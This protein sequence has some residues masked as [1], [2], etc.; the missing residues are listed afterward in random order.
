M[1]ISFPDFQVREFAI[2]K[3]ESFLNSPLT[4]TAFIAPGGYGKTTIV[5]QLVEIFFTGPHARYPNDIVCL[6]DGSI[7]LNLINL[8]LEVVRLKNIFEFEQRNSF[9]VYFRKHPEQVRGRFV[10]IIESLYQIYHQE[11]KLNHFVENLMDIVSAYEDVSWFKLLITCR[12]DNWKSFSNLILKDPHLESMW[13]D[14][15]FGGSGN[16]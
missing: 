12:P 7:L 1:E 10:L 8:N 3:F 11:E 15:H 2:K 16:R 14:V 6:V 13:F 5:A 4:A 9:S